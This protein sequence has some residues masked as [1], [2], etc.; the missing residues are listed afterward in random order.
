[1]NMPVLPAVHASQPAADT[2]ARAADASASQDTP[3]FSNVLSN[4]RGAAAG[5]KAPATT[6]RAD[7]T[8]ADADKKQDP[9]GPDETLALILDSAALPLMQ[10]AAQTPAATRHQTGAARTGIDAEADAP[11][12]SARLGANT[13]AL[14][15]DVDA[16]APQ[17]A[18]DAAPASR[19]SP[20][21][22]TGPVNPAML[23]QAQAAESA[24][25][26]TPVN[27]PAA[28]SRGNTSLPAADGKA[29][30]A[31]PLAAASGA[32][33][34]PQATPLAVAQDAPAAAQQ[35]AAP[36]G[37]TLLPAASSPS[38]AQAPLQLT[39]PTPLGS[40]QW[41]QDFS[42][43]VLSLTQSGAATGHVVTMH[44]NPPELGP[45]HITLHLGDTLAQASFVSPHANVRQALENALPHLE[46]QLAQAG[47]SLGQANVSDQQPGQQQFGQP[48][49]NASASD[50]PAFSL[51][52]GTAAPA[53]AAPVS[54]SRPASR[55]DALVDTFA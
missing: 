34:H 42:R 53:P 28:G 13:A 3:A 24:P 7:A 4:Q 48:A 22:N 35:A 49:S 38:S 1:M 40:P 25:A 8:R 51:D 12:S 19:V 10:A 2:P 43:Q 23:A 20:R 27:R 54:A 47:L 55:P 41:P 50:G 6:G 26:A 29:A 14:L 45:I 16:D 17:D 31:T 30:L 33:A 32:T 37:A 9:L 11:V 36:L 39:V 18:A 15:A 52:G 46:Q 21:T 5:D 44:V